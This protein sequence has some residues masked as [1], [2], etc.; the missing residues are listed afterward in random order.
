MVNT[1]ARRLNLAVCYGCLVYVNTNILQT[2]AKINLEDC[3]T[4][5]LS[6]LHEQFV[7]D[8]KYFGVK[9]VIHWIQRGTNM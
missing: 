2:S 3:N 9:I 7:K 4:D 5:N 1:V 6:D 8:P